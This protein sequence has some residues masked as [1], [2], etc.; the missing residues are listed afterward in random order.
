MCR[1]SRYRED[2]REE[3]GHADVERQPEDKTHGCRRQGWAEQG[4]DVGRGAH[5]REVACA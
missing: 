2:R 5:V 3:Q 1:E 4:D